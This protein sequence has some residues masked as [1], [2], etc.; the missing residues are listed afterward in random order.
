MELVDGGF[1][2]NSPIEAA[3]LWGATHIILIEASPQVRLERT[4]FATNAMA[5]FTHL[6]EQSQLLDARARGKVAIFTLAP[7]PPHVCVL[8]FAD[9]LIEDSI[10][11]GYNDALGLSVDEFGDAK[12][13]QTTSG[14]RFRKELGEPVFVDL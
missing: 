12:A 13:G 11:R 6:Y 1:A 10:A 4:N 5:S 8:D 7:R 9:N 3:V 2:H 14:G